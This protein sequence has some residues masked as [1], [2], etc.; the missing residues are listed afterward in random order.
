MHFSTKS[1]VTFVLSLSSFL[2]LSQAQQYAGENINNTLQAVAGAELAFFKIHDSKNQTATLLNYYSLASTGARINPANAKRAVIVIHG[3][4]RDPYLYINNAMKALAQVTDPNINKDNVAMIAP[5][6]TNGDDKGVAYPWTTGLKAG[7]GSTSNA[8]VWSGSQWASGGDNQYPAYPTNITS[9]S[10]YDVLDQLIQYFD[11]ATLFPN[12][13]QIV[14]AGHSLGG[15]TVQRYATVGNLLKTRSAVTYWSGNPDSYAWFSMDKPRDRSTCA[16]YDDWRFGFSNYNIR[17]GSDLVAQ[18]RAAAL[19]RF[20]SRRVTFGRGT[21][22]FGDDSTNCAPNTTGINRGERFFNLIKQ[23][24]I[25]CANPSVPGSACT[26]VDYVKLGHDAGGMM[27]SP[28]GRAR[29]F[30][31]NFNGD[32]SFAYNFGYPRLQ[33]GDD[34]YPDPALAPTAKNWTTIVYPSNMTYQGC[35]TNTNLD[36]LSY[37]AYRGNT[38]TTVGGCTNLCLGAGYSTAGLAWGYDCYCGNSVSS[39]AI[40]TADGACTNPCSGSTSDFCGGQD[41]LAIYN[42]TVVPTTSNAVTANLTCTNNASNGTVYQAANGGT[43]QVLCS[44]DTYGGDISGASSPS[45]AS[46]IET[47]DK[48]A[49]CIDASYTG[50]NCWL[51]SSISGFYSNTA[52]VSA[53][54]ISLSCANGAGD[55]TIITASNGGNYQVLCS[56]DSYGGDISGAASSSL[57]ACLNTCDQTTGCI[58]VSYTGGNCWLKS[59]I[60][61]F[62]ANTNVISGKKVVSSATTTTTT[63]ASN[64]TSLSCTN[65]ASNG[66]T[67]KAASG[68]SYLIRCQTD[69]YG[70][71]IGS[72]TTT[73][74]SDCVDACDATSGCVD[75]SFLSA[76]PNCW[77]KGSPLAVG[78]AN[79]NVTSAEKLA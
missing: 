26:T 32:G 42:T 2:S 63:T 70:G 72:R 78:Y 22:D 1:F 30:Q 34:Q 39:T 53:K 36:T 27:S 16:T 54:K 69:H 66:T 35:Y 52:V 48:T 62:Y 6:F 7:R 57:A 58:D 14:I 31:D 13:K 9:I 15:Q 24:P 44:Q 61:G 67:Y 46:C 40:Q 29:L 4:L 3:L 76:S 71:D 23:F 47:C 5:Y 20:N 75:I 73:S 77:L 41:V 33:S 60:S 38:S 51:K 21:L 17:Y 10:S 64:T 74:L 50:G 65:N 49:N 18:G 79:A 8:I 12:M 19:A 28:A 59:S 25:S 11:D 68:G 43:Y 45:L 56:Q 55:G 37:T